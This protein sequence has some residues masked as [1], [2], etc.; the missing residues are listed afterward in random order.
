MRLPP[1][2]RYH[3]HDLHCPP[4]AE[5]SGDAD[6]PLLNLCESNEFLR[7]SESRSTVKNNADIRLTGAIHLDG[8][9]AQR[10]MKARVTD[11]G[12]TSEAFAVADGVKQGCVLAHTLLGSMFS[13]ML[14]NAY[15]D[16]RPVIR[17]AHRTDG[18]LFTQRRM[19]FMSCVS[20]IFLADECALNVTSKG[21]IQR[22]IEVF[23]PACDNFGLIIN[24]EKAVVVHKP[25]P[26][27]ACVAL[28]IN[29]NGA[30]L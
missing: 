18:Q 5:V 30:Q 2:S 21:D 1:S 29:V 14:F 13:D 4:T 26:D 7:L 19:Q 25:P 17:V 27:A 8:A 9:S 12:C 3:R 22:S 6:T 23:D 11:N 10:G 20:T 16:G 28:Q 24:M 15:R